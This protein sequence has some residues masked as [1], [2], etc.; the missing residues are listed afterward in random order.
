MSFLE[1][2]SSNLR[3]LETMLPLFTLPL[4]SFRFGF[5][6]RQLLHVLQH[7]LRLI[8]EMDLE[9]LAS[10]DA[11]EALV[12][13]SKFGNMSDR[14]DL[15]KF[16]A[17]L[18]KDPQQK[19]TQAMI[20]HRNSVLLRLCK[21]ISD[22]QCVIQEFLDRP[23]IQ[24]NPRLHSLLGLLHL[25]QAE[26]WAYQFSHQKVYFEAQ[27][28]GPGDGA[29]AM[30]L[31]VLRTKFKVLGQSYKG[32][33]LFEDAKSAFEG[34]LAVMKP[35]DSERFLIKSHLADMY[36]EVEYLK[37]KE[38][39]IPDAIYLDEAEKLVSPDIKHLRNSSRHPRHLRRLLLSLLEIEM[40][41]GRQSVAERLIEEVLASY[42][43]ITVP[44]INDQVGHV[45]ALIAWAR[46]SEPSEAVVRWHTA[47]QWNKT[48]N[49]SEDDVFTCAV[50]FLFISLA[51][52]KIG[53]ADESR[54]SFNRAAEIISR[55][56]PQFLIP[57]V[58]SYLYDFA[59]QELLLVAGWPLP[60]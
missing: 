34:C 33:G 27:K 8:L 32:E 30:Q 56:Q 11:V 47:F 25:S 35:Q 46:I 52:Y 3:K 41:R 51:N 39:A 20:V 28:W 21:K 5:V 60:R 42:N 55:K 44:D 9:I 14:E 16:A 6:G 12:A 31:Y 1:I 50:I 10:K 7:L 19:D 15:L 26:N 43:N 45:R 49:P 23:F 59:Q 36:C 13:A 2:R 4:I 37:R 57:G 58:G 29:S 40:I 54:A 18:Q 22:S 24:P 38:L 17:K 53:N 48:Y